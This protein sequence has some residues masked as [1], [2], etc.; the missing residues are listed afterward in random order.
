MSSHPVLTA[1]EQE[2]LRLIAAG[3][4]N[5]HIAAAMCISCKT[6][7]AHKEH[8]KDKLGLLGATALLIEA[9]RRYPDQEAPVP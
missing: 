8:I 2:V 7:Q 3:Y 1:R 4:S 5:R 9:L 6:V